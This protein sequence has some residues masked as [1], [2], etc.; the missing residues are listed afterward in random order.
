MG[1]LPAVFDSDQSKSKGFL[2]KLRRYFLLNHQVPTLRSYL[3][4]IALAL[5]LIQGPLV[6]EWARNHIDWLERMMLLDYELDT[7]RQ[8]AQ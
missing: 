2:D 1:K 3:T 8:F 5:T 7:W 6:E 4:R